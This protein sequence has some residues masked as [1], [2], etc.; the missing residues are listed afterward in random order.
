M[1]AKMLDIFGLLASIVVLVIVVFVVLVVGLAYAAAGKLVRPPRYKR[2]WTPKDLG[3][4]YEEVAVETAD[5]LK[6]KGWFID[7]GSSITILAI[8]GYTASKWDETYMKPVISILARNGFNVAAF[9]LRAHG[10]SEGEITTLGYKEVRDYMRII[11]WL[12][13]NKPGKAEKIGVIGYSMGGSVAIML[14]AMDKRVNAAVADSPY[15]DI[16]ASGRRWI[17]RL[18][19]FIKNVLIL[20]YPLIV[21]IASRKAEL[22]IDDLMMY[23]YAG[24]IRIPMLIIAGEKDDLVSIDEIK[25]F[26][27]ELKNHNENAELWITGSAHVRSIVDKPEEYEEKVIGFFRRWLS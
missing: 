26:F 22:N 16:V 11:D 15:I 1:G 21:M 8:H 6:L 18:K 13:Q 4:D 12:K 2:S 3:Y 19:G 10:E 25:K 23:N 7:R 17:N 9:D 20:G 14:S 27:E 5:G 24:R